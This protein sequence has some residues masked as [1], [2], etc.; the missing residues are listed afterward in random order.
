ME[1]AKVDE[2]GQGRV[3]SGTDAKTIG[4]IDDFGG[5]ND[6][7]AQAAELAGVTEYNLISLPAQKDPLQQI[8]DD[9]TGNTNNTR[10]AK[11]L[12]EFYPYYNYL[13]QV[14]EYQGVQARLPFEV[15]IN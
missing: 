13:K 3:W 15:Q 14:K 12:G 5:L 1:T 8:I 10:I 9:L 7:I 11:E 6:A 2:V 4:L